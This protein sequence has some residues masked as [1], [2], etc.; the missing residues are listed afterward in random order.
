MPD[1]YQV[2]AEIRQARLA[3]RVFRCLDGGLWQAVAYAG[4]QL[5][6]FS[7]KSTEVD[8]LMTLRARFPGGAM[9]AFVGAD[10]VTAC[11]IKATR[12]AGGDRLRWRADKWRE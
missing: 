11:I 4:G 3:E 1:K 5:E 7:V 10:T 8:A 12:E 9:V 6:G 2:E